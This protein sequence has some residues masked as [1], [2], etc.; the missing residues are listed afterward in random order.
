MICLFVMQDNHAR[1]DNL[2]FNAT[3]EHQKN[4]LVKQ[5]VDRRARYFDSPLQVGDKT[6]RYLD[7][8]AGAML[9]AIIER[10]IPVL[11]TGGWFDGFAKATPKFHSTLQGKSPSYLHMGPQFHGGDLWLPIGRF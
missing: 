2:L 9:G 5:F 8:S 10:Q 3:V 7:T 11:N 1:L 4:T 6:I